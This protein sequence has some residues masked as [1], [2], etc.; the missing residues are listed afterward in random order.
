MERTNTTRYAI[1]SLKYL[2]WLIVLFCA[3]MLLLTLSGYAQYSLEESLRQ[4]TDSHQGVVMFGAIILLAL[5]Y[6][7]FGFTTRSCA[8]EME[9][10]REVILR[11]MSVSGFVLQAEEPGRLVFRAETPLKRLLLLGEDEVIITAHGEQ[12]EIT[13]A[14]KEVVRIQFRLRSFLSVPQS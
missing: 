6:P 8:A 13:G 7:R 1:R 9:S 5:L 4:L 14:R 2:L 11:T 12:I 3:L 10:R